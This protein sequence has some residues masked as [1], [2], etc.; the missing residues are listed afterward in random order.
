MDPGT[1]LAIVGL[2]LDAVK[3]LHSYYVIWKDR[4]RDVEE[5]GQQLIWLM[6]LFHTIQIT[7]KQ[8]DL[9]PAQVQMICGSIKKCEEIITKL[10]VK[11]AKAKRE[12]DPDTLLKK[13]D[14]QRRRAL[15]P[16]KKGTIGGLLDLIDSCKE[17]MK[18]VIPLL[19]L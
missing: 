15:Y 17:E 6:N 7:L 16:F 8:D 5:V 14:D 4:D 19:N 3:D 9:N 10:K 12:G 18:I 11:L 2:G 1:A 13:L